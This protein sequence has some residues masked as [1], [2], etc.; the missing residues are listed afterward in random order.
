M[1]KRHYYAMHT[2]YGN[3]TDT[4]NIPV[5]TVLIFDGKKMRDEWVEDNEYD[6]RNGNKHQTKVITEHEARVTMLRQCGREMCAWHNRNG[7]A[8]PYR[9][10]AQFCPTAVMARDYTAAIGADH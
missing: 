8:W 10:Y 9:D 3:I 7:L 4:D 2:P 1:N 5:G 6:T